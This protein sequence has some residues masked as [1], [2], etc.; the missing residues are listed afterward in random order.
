MY[1]NMVEVIGLMLCVYYH[2]FLKYGNEEAAGT[3]PHRS[4]MG[5]PAALPEDEGLLVC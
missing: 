5:G 4:Q 3:Q 1:L 2:K